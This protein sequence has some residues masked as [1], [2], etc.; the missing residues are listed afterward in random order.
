MRIVD[1]KER[2]REMEKMGEGEDWSIVR[3]R[4]KGAG[5]EISVS[6]ILFV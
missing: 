1:G 2:E 3:K 5:E 6:V 4:W